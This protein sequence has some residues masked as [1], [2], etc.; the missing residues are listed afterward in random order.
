M[1]IG[2]VGVVVIIGLLLTTNPTAFANVFDN[3]AA[4][5]GVQTAYENFTQAGNQY[6]GGSVPTGPTSGYTITLIPLWFTVLFWVYGSNYLAGETK[7]IKRSGKI[8]LFGGFLVIFLPTLLVL[9]I[10]YRTLG[11]DFLAGAGYYGLG[12]ASNPLP[13]IPNLTLFAGILTNNPILVWFI[14]IGVIAGFLLVAPQSIF[15]QSR[16]LFAYAFDRLTPAF[17]ADVNDRW[18]TPVKAIVI[19]AGVAEIF[20]LFLSGVIGPANAATAFLLYSYAGLAAIALT[21]VFISI[22]AILFPFRRR[23]LYETACPIKRKVLGVPVIT[24]L[25]VVSLAYCLATVGYY[26][27]NYLFYFG[28]G[29]LAANLYFPFLEA[30]AGLFVAC[31]VW[32]FIVAWYRS[33]ACLPFQKAFQQIPPE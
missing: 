1:I 3:Y 20:L 24:W 4:K 17:V 13:V 8:A 19:S 27:Y 18:Y 16:Q 7:E 12:Y 30:L 14:G 28:A 25:G 10:A 33:K 32:F 5:Q 23:E 11:A 22:S 2:M 9:G 31:I 21:F 26:S 6:W 15:A 29:T